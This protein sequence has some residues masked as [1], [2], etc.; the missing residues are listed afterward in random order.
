MCALFPSLL[1][2]WAHAPAMSHSVTSHRIN[3]GL[4]EMIKE[5]QKTLTLSR[6]AKD[7]FV[8]KVTPDLGLQRLV[9]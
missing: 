4:G 1:P 6:E 8:E 7:V 3:R 2:S 5:A 9:R